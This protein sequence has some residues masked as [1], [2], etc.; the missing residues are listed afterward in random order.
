MGKRYSNPPIIEVVCEFRLTPAREWDSTIPGL[1]YKKIDKDFPVKEE[2]QISEIEISTT[3]TGIQ[4]RMQRKSIIRF[5]NKGKKNIHTDGP[6]SLINTLLEALSK[7]GGFQA[8]HYK[9]F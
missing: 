5:L 3:E 6:I 4:Q 8:Q 9:S 2:K 1:F 7:M